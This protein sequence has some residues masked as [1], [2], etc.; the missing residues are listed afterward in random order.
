MSNAVNSTPA[1]DLAAIKMVDTSKLKST[2]TRLLVSFAQSSFGVPNLSVDSPTLKRS[3]I[4]YAEFGQLS[5]K[6]FSAGD[7]DS[8]R[9]ITREILD[10]LKASTAPAAKTAYE[11]LNR[12]AEPALKHSEELDQGET[13]FKNNLTEDRE[14]TFEILGKI[15]TT[16]ASASNREEKEHSQ[17]ILNQL[18]TAEKTYENLNN[19]Y[20]KLQKARITSN[21][22]LGIFSQRGYDALPT[23]VG[24]APPPPIQTQTTT[25]SK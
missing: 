16:V 3:T 24:V 21:M 25:L 4:L 10:K 7:N 20:E 15:L 18:V 23:K 17:E 8:I 5:E 12:E 6:L 11:A 13:V 1:L 22:Q 14:K 2:T 19:A 9:G